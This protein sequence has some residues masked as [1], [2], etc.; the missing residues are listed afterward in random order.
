MIAQPASFCA[1]LSALSPWYS[2][3]CA[4]VLCQWGCL[5]QWLHLQQLHEPVRQ[6]F[7]QGET[8][9]WHSA[10]APSAHKLHRCHC[11]LTTDG[12]KVKACSLRISL[13]CKLPPTNS[14]LFYPPPHPPRTETLH[15][16]RHLRRRLRLPH[17]QAVVRQWHLQGR[18]NAPAEVT[19]V[20]SL[21]LHFDRMQGGTPAHLCTFIALQAA[22]ASGSL[23]VNCVCPSSGFRCIG[24]APGKCTVRMG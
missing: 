23:C 11:L 21:L 6:R 18:I 16:D 3:P 1:A 13:C 7:L 19:F 4:A 12:A 8:L 22:C 20:Q 17:K 14:P 9:A 5:H 15:G 2:R 10:H 24:T